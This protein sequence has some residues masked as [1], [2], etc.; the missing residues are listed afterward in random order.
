M[1]RIREKQFLQAVRDLARLLG[2]LEYRAWRV[3]WSQFHV[4]WGVEQEVEQLD[5][6]LRKL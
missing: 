5:L 1:A 3:K 6:A 4:L 2:W